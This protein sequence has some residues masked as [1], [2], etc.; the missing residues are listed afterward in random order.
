MSVRYPLIVSSSRRHERSHDNLFLSI[1]CSGVCT[2]GV[3]GLMR[4][5]L[6]SEF[7]CCYHAFYLFSRS[8]L[9]SS[10]CRLAEDSVNLDGASMPH[11][12]SMIGRPR[13]VWIVAVS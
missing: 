8:V 1:V 7:P 11:N 13:L 5:V 3:L 10:S 6:I 9:A 4:L 12:V 2:E